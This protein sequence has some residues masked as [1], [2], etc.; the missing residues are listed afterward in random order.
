[1]TLIEQRQYYDEVHRITVARP[2]GEPLGLCVKVEG[3]CVVVSRII[4]GGLIEQNGLI[5]LGDIIVEI[6]GAQINT[7][8]DLMYHV[9]FLNLFQE[10]FLY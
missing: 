4:E 7:P 8:D 6:G 1:M 9:S 3:D 5:D 2:H 10:E